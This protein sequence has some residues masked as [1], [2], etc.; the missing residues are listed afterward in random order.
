M[1]FAFVCLPATGHVNPTLPLVAELVRRGHR[2]TY[3]TSAKYAA[4]VES[5]GAS[6]FENGE[7]LSAQFPRFGNTAPGSPGDD[8]GRSP[9]VGMLA[10]LGAG[11]MSGLLDRLLE[12]AREDFPALLA[13]LAADQPDAVC[14]D[15]MTLAGKM[16]AMKLSLPDIALLPTY[17]TNEH[18]SMRELMPTRPPAEMLRAWKQARQLIGDFAAEQGLAGFNFMEGPPASLNICFIPREFQP[19]GDT[20]DDRFHFVGPSLGR[21]VDGEEWEPRVKEGP[22]LFISLGTTPLNDRPDFFRMCLEAFAGTKW[23]VAMAIGDRMDGAE[24]GEIPESVEVRPFFPQLDVLRHADVFLSHTGMNSTMEALYLAV[25]I[26]AFPLQPEQEANARRV[27]DLGLGRRLP[28]DAVTPQLIH[29]VV[30]DVSRDQGIRSAVA[31]MSQRV[32]SSGGAAAAAD[33]M[34]QYLSAPA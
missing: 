18:F 4:A 27:E 25:P 14:Y 19:A 11:M 17:A 12:R 3:V 26:V 2:V 24:L 13:K 28:T 30:T 1:H 23:Q 10:G 20:F 7:D 9:R 15:A 5:A 33:A 34:E 21:R 16:A 22:L 8:A 31:A 29:D 6:F 32:G